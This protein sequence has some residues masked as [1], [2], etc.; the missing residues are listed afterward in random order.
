MKCEF[1]ET[2]RLGD[3]CTRCGYVLTHDY[4][5]PLFRNCKGPPRLG[6]HV[7]RIIRKVWKRKCG[8]CRKRQEE[9]NQLDEKVRRFFKGESK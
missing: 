2:L 4:K 9:L 5:P 7:A 6:D 3:R 8:G 1:P